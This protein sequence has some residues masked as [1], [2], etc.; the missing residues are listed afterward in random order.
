MLTS[1]IHE[2][3]HELRSRAMFKN[4]V[5]GP[6]SRTHNSNLLANYQVELYCAQVQLVYKTNLKIVLKIDSF[7]NRTELEP[8]FFQTEHRTV[9]ERINSFTSLFLSLVQTKTG[10]QV[11]F[12]HMKDTS[13][14]QDASHWSV[15]HVHKLK[16]SMVLPLSQ[17]IVYVSFSLLDTLF[18]ALIK[19]SSTTYF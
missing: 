10:C 17:S 19:H 12:H 2:L 4:Q 7:M 13:K 6:S 8:S 1:S 15:G 3:V 14:K 11:K 9:I 16:S 18:K 5:Y